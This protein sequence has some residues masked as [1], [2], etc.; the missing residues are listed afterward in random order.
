MTSERCFEPK[1]LIQMLS[2]T[3]T[4][5]TLISCFYA[6][7]SRILS[8]LSRIAEPLTLCEKEE[9]GNAFKTCF[10]WA[11]VY[12]ECLSSKNAMH[13]CCELI[14][15]WLRLSSLYCYDNLQKCF[16]HFRHAYSD[17]VSPSIAKISHHKSLQL[18]TDD[19]S[20]HRTHRLV[21]AETRRIGFHLEST[22]CFLCD[23][24]MIS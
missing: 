11:A 13:Q 15:K 23:Q 3:K 12:Q 24:T 18:H 6:V 1:N 9:K 4:T 7:Q 5:T 2:Y 21:Y 14:R 19:M 22:T 16:L 20:R 10:L 8:L 17:C